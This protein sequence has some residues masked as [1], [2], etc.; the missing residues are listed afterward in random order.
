M[1]SRTQD[2]VPP[3]TSGAQQPEAEAEAPRPSDKLKLAI[4]RARLDDSERTKVVAELRGAEIARLE[5]LRDEL[6]PVAAEIPNDVDLFDIG[7]VSTERPRLF[8]DMIGFVEMGHDRR[9][10]RF[11][12]DTRHGRVVIAESERMEPIVDAVTDY[13]ARRLI[14]REKALAADG[15]LEQAARAYAEAQEKIAA[16]HQALAAAR[17]A[18]TTPGPF[19]RAL[20][21][22]IEI[23]GS[24]LLFAS[25]A[26]GAYTAWKYLAAL[27]LKHG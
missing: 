4:R 21:F 1:D 22:I 18:A 10:Y 3:Q 16:R 5:M 25:L 11:I 2:F 23:L 8:I 9:T 19:G 12:Q 13:I 17:E 26:V 14:E 27:P 15:T 20:A 6:L 7:L 24:A